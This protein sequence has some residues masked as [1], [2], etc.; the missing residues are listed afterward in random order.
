MTLS[1][2]DSELVNKTLKTAKPVKKEEDTLV[3]ADNDYF[4]AIKNIGLEELEQTDVPTPSVILVQNNSTLEDAN[5][6]PYPRGKFVYK[7]T[8]EVMSEVN[9]SILTF[10]KKEFPSFSNKEVM[11]KTYVFLGALT[12]NMQ[13]F[14]LYLK[15][16]GIGAAKQY[17]GQVKSKGVP[18]FAL[19]TR[20]TSEKREGEKGSYYVIKFNIDGVRESVKE[21]RF[22]EELVNRYSA[23]K[24]EVKEEVQEVEVKDIPF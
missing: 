4:Q 12:P 13:P 14:V 24:D 8:G 15:R 18:M 22:L 21:L 11:E 5:G 20:L 1:E 3:K 19:K 10:T 16:T 23:V 17:F 6:N 7:G 2:N 9:C